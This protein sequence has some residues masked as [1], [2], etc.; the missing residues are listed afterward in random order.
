M[1]LYVLETLNGGLNELKKSQLIVYVAIALVTFLVGYA[2]RPM[3]AP[4]AEAPEAE[5]F[6]WT[7]QFHGT[8]AHPAFAVYQQW[9]KDIEQ[10][11]AGR[12]LITVH[13]VGAVVPLLESLGAVTAGTLDGAVM[14]GPFWRGT[15]PVLALACGQ[16]SGLTPTEYDAWLYAH[17]GLALLQEAYARHNIHWLP[18]VPMPPETFLWAHRPILTVADLQGLKVRAA[19]FALDT[20]T[21]MGAAASFIPGGDTPPALMQRVVDAAEFGALVQDVAVGFADAAKFAMVGPRAPVLS[22][23]VLINMNRW[24]ELPVDLQDILHGA[25]SRLTLSESA[26]LVQKDQVAMQT[27]IGKGVQFIPVPDALMNEFR[28]TLDGI[29]D[30]QAA[31][32]AN[33]AKIWTSLRTFREEYRQFTETLYPWE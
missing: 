28:T 13:P 33:F 29:L 11:S 9:A 4:V 2:V 32:N 3:I 18:A 15:D 23:D 17:G 6:T 26:R 20:F 12:L 27:A 16:T 30:A 21:A 8:T 25:L 5:V 1:F 24:G 19:G 31:G 7:F 10:M 22:D 14:W